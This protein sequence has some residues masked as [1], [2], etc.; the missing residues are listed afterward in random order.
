MPLRDLKPD[1]DCSQVVGRL[2]LR[3]SKH[4]QEVGEVKLER[5]VLLAREHLRGQTLTQ[6][7]VNVSSQLSVD[8]EEDLNKLSDSQLQ[9]RK[10]IMEFNFEKNNVKKGDPAFVY[11]KEVSFGTLKEAAGWDEESEEEE[12]GGTPRNEREEEEPELSNPEKEEEEDFW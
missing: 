6:A 2:R 3:H 4:L 5:L 12:E 10:D 11:D 9:R 7:L 8:P 1:S